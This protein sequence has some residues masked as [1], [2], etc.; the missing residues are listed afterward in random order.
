MR[1]K[2]YASIFFVF[3]SS[4]VYGAR[5]DFSNDEDYSNTWIY[6]LYWG[7]WCWLF[8]VYFPKRDNNHYRMKKRF[9]NSKVKVKK[10]NDEISSKREA[11]IEVERKAKLRIA[12]QKDSALL[13]GFKLRERDIPTHPLRKH[14]K[15]RLY[16]YKFT[17]TKKG[18]VSSTQPM[19]GT[20][21]ISD[22]EVPVREMSGSQSEVKFG[23]TAIKPEAAA[24]MNLSVGDELPLEL[25]DKP[26]VDSNGEV[27]SNLFWAH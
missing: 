11:E 21:L 23:F 8:F 10:D 26:V 3:F 14:T 25:T 5:V 19:K 16:F 13:E 24:Q 20:N 12:N 9:D 1:I 22:V 15:T 6:I 7:F 2:Y 27:I 18:I 4:V 17:Q